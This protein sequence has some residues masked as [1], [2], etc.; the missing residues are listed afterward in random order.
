MDVR[1]NTTHFGR[2]RVV[3]VKVV[4]A[5]SSEGFLVGRPVC[6][7]ADDIFSAYVC[8]LFHHYKPNL[9]DAPMGIS[10]IV[11]CLCRTDDSL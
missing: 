8:Y 4:G 7:V 6:V 11:V 1:Y 10:E 9:R 3:C 2:C 5:T